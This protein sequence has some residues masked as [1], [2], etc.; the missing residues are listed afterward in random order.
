VA[1]WLGNILAA[2]FQSGGVFFLLASLV[3]MLIIVHKHGKKEHVLNEKA[4]LFHI[5]S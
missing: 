4:A 5:H 2:T 3:S 1:K